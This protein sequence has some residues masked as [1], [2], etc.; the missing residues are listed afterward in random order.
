[1]SLI[2]NQVAVPANASGAVFAALLP[3][4]GTVTFSVPS[5]GQTV[6][7]GQSVNVT[8]TNGFPVNPGGPQLNFT[9]PPTAQAVN[10]WVINSGST[11]T[12]IGVAVTVT[13]WGGAL[14]RINLPEGCYG[15]S[16]AGFKTPKVKPGSSVDIDNPRVLRLIRNSS[17]GELGILS[18]R[19]LVSIRTK[20]GRKCEPCNRIWQA[21]TK[22]CPKC[23]AETVPE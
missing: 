5:G 9:L 23:G 12:V 8:T 13:A 18:H 2:L 14:T 7:V 1:M 21:W 11:P 15:L 3:S 4:N 19:E 16:L 6:Y 20:S 22:V 10:L 17:N